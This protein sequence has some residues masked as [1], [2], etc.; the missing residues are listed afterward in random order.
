[1]STTTRTPMTAAE[2][3]A[4]AERKTGNVA[5]AA[6]MAAVFAEARA[7]VAAGRCPQCGSALRRNLS[8]TGW[9][10]CEQYGTVAFRARPA[11]PPCSWQTFTE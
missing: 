10:Q 9:W 2:K 5:R 1:M 8:M 11:E 7:L 3:I 6:R 4:R